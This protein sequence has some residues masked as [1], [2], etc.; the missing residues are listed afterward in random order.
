MLMGDNSD[1]GLPYR[2]TAA[3]GLLYSCTFL[4]H[5]SSPIFHSYPLDFPCSI[6]VVSAI[7]ST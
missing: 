4:R 2:W 5:F 6:T 3:L 1:E 7:H